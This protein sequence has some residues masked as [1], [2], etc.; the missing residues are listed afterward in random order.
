MATIEFFRDNHEKIDLESAL[1]GLEVLYRD[2]HGAAE[3]HCIEDSSR[4]A[5]F[6]LDL[7][8]A[9]VLKALGSL[10]YNNLAQVVG[11]GRAMKAWR[12][13]KQESDP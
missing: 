8:M 4:A 5:Q 6:D 2:L 12:L 1:S 9:D 7:L 3:L 13:L 11:R 10:D